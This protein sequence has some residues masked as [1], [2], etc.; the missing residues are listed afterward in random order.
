MGI[1]DIRDLNNSRFCKLYGDG[2]IQKI[3]FN[4]DQDITFKIY[5]SDGELFEASLTDNLLPS[6]VDPDLQ[7][8]ALFEII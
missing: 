5:L 3:R 6:E 1:T 4:S 2:Q 8:S 7:I